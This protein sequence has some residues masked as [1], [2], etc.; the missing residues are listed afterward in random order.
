MVLDLGRKAIMKRATSA[1]FLV[2][3]AFFVSAFGD[4]SP[5]EISDEEILAYATRPYNKY[6]IAQHRVVLGTRGRAI[7]LA[8][9]ICSDLCPEYT[10]RV[11]RYELSKDQSCL[12]V[13]GIEKE[14]R[15]PV[16]IAA[17][18]KT[19]C[20]PK[21]LVDNWGSYTKTQ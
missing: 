15:V 14:V 18:N 3:T 5:P 12:E 19:F 20:F 1:I 4:A 11:V 2:V 17:M 8:E 16:A 10:V 13:G 9:Y 21:V 7:V 6:K